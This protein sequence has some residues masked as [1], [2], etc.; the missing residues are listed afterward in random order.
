MFDAEVLPARAACRGVERAGCGEDCVTN[1]LGF[2]PPTVLP[3]EQRIAGI[4]GG[5]CRIVVGALAPRGASDDEPM[6]IFERAA[7]IAELGRQPVEE[8]R[9]ARRGAHPAEITRRVDD[10]AAEMVEPG[11]VD[12]APPGERVVGRDEPLGERLAA[13]SLL[14]TG[15]KL[16]PGREHGERRKRSGADL[17]ARRADVAAGKEMD[18][19]GHAATLRRCHR[20]ERPQ[21]RQGLTLAGN[22]GKFLL[23]RTEAVGHLGRHLRQKLVALLAEGRRVSAWRWKG[24]IDEI[25]PL[26]ARWSLDRIEGGDGGAAGDVRAVGIENVEL[27]DRGNEVVLPGGK[28]RGSDTDMSDRPDRSAVDGEGLWCRARIGKIVG[29]RVGE[30]NDVGRER[31]V[32]RA[33]DP[34]STGE[35]EPGA[36]CIEI[37]VAG[38]ENDVRDR[39]L[40]AEIDLHPFLRVCRRR[41][42]RG[43]DFRMPAKSGRGVAS[44]GGGEGLVDLGEAGTGGFGKP[45]LEGFLAA[46]EIGAAGIEGGMGSHHGG[47]GGI[48]PLGAIEGGKHGLE[49]VVILL[50]DRIE[51]VRVALGALDRDTREGADRVGDHVV[52]VEMAGD[53]AVG[54]RLRHLDVADEIP[55]AS[56]KHAGCLESP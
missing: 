45:G 22:A 43:N 1:R 10:A 3:P 9:V 33:L 11:A 54:L 16:E 46:V 8:G 12:G 53:L 23:D 41:T 49:G 18:R 42:A 50:G 19:A 28:S 35:S 7:P 47:I 51:L 52:A 56:G 40:A 17:A 20:V 31:R 15:R 4:D 55:R 44:A 6:K 24:A 21:R 36:N 30:P 2:E 14:G 34:E 27:G 37:V 26:P 13:V 48:G 5:S 38:M 25:R 39:H 32:A 29:A